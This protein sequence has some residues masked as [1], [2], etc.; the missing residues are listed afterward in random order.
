MPPTEGGPAATGSELAAFFARKLAARRKLAAGEISDLSAADQACGGATALAPAATLPPPLPAAALQPAAD[1]QALVRQHERTAVEDL[2]AALGLPK[3]AGVAEVEAAAEAARQLP[4]RL[5]AALQALQ[6]ARE[7]LLS[8]EGAKMCANAALQALLG[9]IQSIFEPAFGGLAAQEDHVLAA[10]R[11]LMDYWRDMCTVAGVLNTQDTTSESMLAAAKKMQGVL[12]KAEECMERVSAAVGLPKDAGLVQLEKRVKDEMKRLQQLEEQVRQTAREL[13]AAHAAAKEAEVK[14]SKA[15]RELEDVP[16]QNNRLQGAVDA[17]HTQQFGLLQH[18]QAKPASLAQDLVQ[19]LAPH[20]GASPTGSPAH[21]EA[22]LVGQLVELAGVLRMHGDANLKEIVVATRQAAK[23][24]DAAKR[25]VKDAEGKLE[26]AKAQHKANEERAA[27]DTQAAK[28]AA[29]KASSDLRAIKI[30]LQ[31]AV[32]GA[33][34]AEERVR[35]NMDCLAAAAG[36]PPGASPEQLRLHVAKLLASHT[37]LA[38][39][40][41]EKAALELEV[42]KL[43]DEAGKLRRKIDS[44]AE[45]LRISKAEAAEVSRDLQAKSTANA[46]LEAVAKEALDRQQKADENASATISSLAGCA[47]LRANARL[48]DLQF[49]VTGLRLSHEALPAALNE[50]AALE[51][52][53]RELQAHLA[54]AERQKQELEARGREAAKELADLQGVAKDTTA[55][56][57]RLAAATGLPAGLSLEQLEAALDQQREDREQATAA[58]QQAQQQAAAAA[59]AQQAQQQAAAAAAA[60]QAQQAQQAHQQPA[61]P[62]PSTALT[63]EQQVM[64]ARRQFC[65]ELRQHTM[66]LSKFETFVQRR[67]PEALARGW[68][69]VTAEA[70]A[71]TGNTASGAANKALARAVGG[72]DFPKWLKKNPSNNTVFLKVARAIRQQNLNLGPPSTAA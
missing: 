52:Q 51:L 14:A 39:V 54:T 8:A 48:G 22:S 66:P 41:E 56:V 60:Q 2:M 31:A 42:Q 32:K 71:A 68:H 11:G 17:L 9:T 67:L 55:T 30:E 19:R 72:D 36:L 21:L 3:G 29:T 23:E 61:A 15:R 69:D 7:D 18:A 44:Q 25:T 63:E 37:K 16:T 27:N 46:K 5:E 26:T 58:A 50:K 1:E 47:G 28:D 64:E 59:A 10:A 24:L 20:V 13:I 34:D 6:T 49:H 45:E 12:C 62:G 4:A 57:D 38:A 65:I 53:V 33:E 40:K 35:S 43:Q 70:L